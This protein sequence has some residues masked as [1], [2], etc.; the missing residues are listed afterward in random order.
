MKLLV[1]SHACVTP[2]NQGFYA[3]VS[4]QMGWD[5]DLI[6][7]SSWKSEYKAMVAASRWKEFQGEIHRF[8]SGAQATFRSMCTGKPW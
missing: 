4:K 1:V 8:Q 2:V 6:I 7:P 5:I 3:E